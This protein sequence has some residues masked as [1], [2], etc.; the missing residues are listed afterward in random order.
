MSW[1]VMDVEFD[2][3]TV[4]ARLSDGEIEVQVL[5][6]VME[7]SSTEA[8]LTGLH[9]QGP[10]PN[11]VGSRIRSIAYWVKEYL[12]V[13]RLRIEGAT[14]TSGASPGRDPAPIVF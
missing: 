9:I 1:T 11:S 12:D 13:S 2:G 5:A 7:L 14:R 10:G 3:M 6:D 8:V 4:L